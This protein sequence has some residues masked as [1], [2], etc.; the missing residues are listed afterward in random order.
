MNDLTKLKGNP[1][2]PQDNDCFIVVPMHA[3]GLTGT[4]QWDGPFK[5]CAEARQAAAMYLVR[6]GALSASVFQL[7]G[8]VTKPV[9]DLEWHEPEKK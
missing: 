7:I 4:A 9:P 5:T 3:R 1:L 8:T 6:T 2:A